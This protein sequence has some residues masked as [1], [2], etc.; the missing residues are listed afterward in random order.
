[1][2][3]NPLFSRIHFR[4]NLPTVQLISLH[5][6]FRFLFPKVEVSPAISLVEWQSKWRTKLYHTLGDYFYS[7]FLRRLRKPSMRATAENS[8]NS[9]T[10]INSKSKESL[11]LELK[12]VKN[13]T[14]WKLFRNYYLILGCLAKTFFFLFTP[15]LNII[16]VPTVV[17]FHIHLLIQNKKAVI[18]ETIYINTHINVS[19]YCLGVA[20]TLVSKCG[21]W[22]MNLVPTAISD[23][24]RT[25]KF[26]C[27]SSLRRQY[28]LSVSLWNAQFN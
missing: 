7:V 10:S 22:A 15:F 17:F 23:L 25:N 20:A 13:L 21:W 24:C 4:T 6:A 9:D 18:H 12:P 28:P 2:A 3:S 8:F 26:F 11:V 1:M 19:L 5:H 16:C 27:G 14:D